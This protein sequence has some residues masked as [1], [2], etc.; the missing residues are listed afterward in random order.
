[1]VFHSILFNQEQV[2]L[3]KEAP[4]FF[5]DLNLVQVV[6]A[7]ISEKQEYDLRP[8]FY[9]LLNSVEAVLYRQEV[10]RDLENTAI[11]GHITS[12]AHAMH[13]MRESLLKAQ[14]YFHKYQQERLFL[15]AVK[16]YCEAVHTLAVN[17]LQD[18]ICSGGL[19]A[20]REYVAKYIKSVSFTNLLSETLNLLSDLS[21]VKYRVLV[22]ELRIQVLPFEEEPDYSHEVERL[23]EKF[24]QG[25]VKDYRQKFP[26]IPE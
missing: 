6:D 25:E 21:K 11:H 10:F 12:F 22:K 20:F 15:D 19:L 7:A 9:T 14:K 23:F 3:V 18:D 26:D 4:A 24:R 8:F 13:E 16:F 5:N 17:L 1:M 2:S